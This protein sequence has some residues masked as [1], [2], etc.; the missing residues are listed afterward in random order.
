MLMYGWGWLKSMSLFHP[1]QRFVAQFSDIAGLAN[2][3]PVQVSGVRV[4]TVERIDLAG[5]GQ[6]KVLVHLKI[7]TEAVKVPRG[8]QI[9]IQTLGLVGAKYVEI[10]LP[11]P[12]QAG[13]PALT[14]FGEDTKDPSK[15]FDDETTVGQDPVRVEMVINDAANRIKEILKGAHG[16]KAESSLAEALEGA[17][18]M[19]KHIDEAAQSFSKNMNKVSSTADTFKDTAS[20][21]GSVAS[22]AKAFFDNG[23]RTMTSVNGLAGDFRHTSTRVNKLL[24]NPA[25]SSDVKSAAESAKDAAQNVSA[26]MDKFKG[27]MADEPTRQALL[28]AL[29]D[30]KA[31]AQ[32]AS[33][34]MTQ[35]SDLAKDKSIR[36]EVSGSIHELHDVVNKANDM[37]NSPS[38]GTDIKET[39]NQVKTSAADIDVAARQAQKIMNQK[40]PL[41]KMIFRRPGHIRGTPENPDVDPAPKHEIHTQNATPILNT[42]G[43]IDNSSGKDTASRP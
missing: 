9:T 39:L 11:P 37:L 20:R 7:N 36:T 2:N 15:K 13:D 5:Q 14:Y 29:S 35:V 1:P 22:D 27:I 33:S 40:H 43:A 4:G 42:T 31:S 26:A 25:F 6:N 10:S 3:A 38:F 30:L 34:V 24:D 17:G 19:V 41:L 32:N 23:S 28:T 16:T 21:F 18:D 8:S 12:P